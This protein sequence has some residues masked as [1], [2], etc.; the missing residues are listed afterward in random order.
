LIE[1]KEMLYAL[2]CHPQPFFREAV[3]R[4]RMRS[5][6]VRHNN[7]HANTVNGEKPL[8]KAHVYCGPKQARRRQTYGFSGLT[9]RETRPG[10]LRRREK[11]DLRKA[12]IQPAKPLNSIQSISD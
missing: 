4:Q 12:A 11:P 10:A 9:G 5:W 2:A 6:Q 7:Y 1:L 8:K 3:K